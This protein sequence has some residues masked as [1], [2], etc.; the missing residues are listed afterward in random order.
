MSTWMNT[1]FVLY[2]PLKLN[3]W[4]RS[5]FTYTLVYLTLRVFSI[6][7]KESSLSDTRCLK[8]EWCNVER[9]F[10]C[11][12]TLLLHHS[13]GIRGKTH[14]CKQCI[15]SNHLIFI[16]SY[17]LSQIH[18]HI[19]ISKGLIQYFQQL[20]SSHFSKRSI[21]GWIYSYTKSDWTVCNV[22]FVNE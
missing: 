13:V 20:Y 17:H 6:E 19:I 12:I 2:H 11:R 4:S 8:Q 18:G 5:N 9:D 21:V 3:K 16:H 7:I 10:L 1:I 15:R 14:Q 22:S